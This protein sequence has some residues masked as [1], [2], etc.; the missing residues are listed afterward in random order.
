MT[1]V[2]LM[3]VMLAVMGLGILRFGLPMLIMW[4]LNLFCCRVLHL[5]A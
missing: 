4:L 1:L 5:P 2:E 3:T